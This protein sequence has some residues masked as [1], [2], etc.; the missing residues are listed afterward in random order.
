MKRFEPLSVIA[1][2]LLAGCGITYPVTIIDD[3]DE[4]VVIRATGKT[5]YEAMSAATAKAQAMLG[6]YTE[7]QPADCNY[8]DGTADSGGAWHDCVIYAKK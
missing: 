8:N 4:M 1:A 6:Q 7:A 3:T 5:K 2:L